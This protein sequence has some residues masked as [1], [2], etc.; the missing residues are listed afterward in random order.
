MADGSRFLKLV[1]L[2]RETASDRRRE[3]LRQVTDLFFE[4]QGARGERENELIGDVLQRVANDMQDGVLAELAERFAHAPD[5]PHG[6]MKDLAAH[7]FEVAA[8]VLRHSPVLQDGDLVDVVENHTQDHIKAIAQR[9]IVSEF[10]SAAIVKNGDDLALDALIRN[11]GAKLSRD[12]MEKVVDRAR[13]STMLHEG[14]IRRA[15]MPLDLV[16][17]NTSWLRRA[18][19]IRS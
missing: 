1:E 16:N 10:V 6:L 17:E 13:G 4:T 19:A 2:A 7:A 14:V 8:P 5:A 11:D 18:C 12:S 15:D 3:L 9:K